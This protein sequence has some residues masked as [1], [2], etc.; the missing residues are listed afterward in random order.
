M[1]T[2]RIIEMHAWQVSLKWEGIFMICIVKKHF[3]FQNAW[4]LKN[5]R[6][7]PCSKK[8]HD[9]CGQSCFEVPFLSRL[10]FWAQVHWVK[11]AVTG[12]TVV[13]FAWVTC[14][15]ATWLVGREE[16]PG[17]LWQVTQ[18]GCSG[19]LEGVTE[20]H[21]VILV[22]IPISF[23][24]VWFDA[25]LFFF[26]C[27]D[28]LGNSLA[29][30]EQI[31]RKYFLFSSSFSQFSPLCSGS[32]RYLSSTGADGTICFWLWDAGTLKIKLVAILFIA[33]SVYVIKNEVQI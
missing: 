23:P 11:T 17:G 10:W 19:V 20:Q 16:V 9:T 21:F 8:L 5:P 33:T 26:S 3:Y 32:K 18:K 27:W 1:R 22:F 6:H 28:E 15:C 29:H 7:N 25:W 12:S 13:L 4:P 31:N 2:F 14:Y 30:L 24:K